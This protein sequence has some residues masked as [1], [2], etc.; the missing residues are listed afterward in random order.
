MSALQ[1]AMLRSFGTEF[2]GTSVKNRRATILDSGTQKLSAK[3]LPNIARALVQILQR[4]K[5]KNRYL[6]IQDFSCS[7]RDIVENLEW[8]SGERWTVENVKTAE[9]V[10]QAR[11]RLAGGDNAAL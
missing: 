11:A 3:M 9:R 6:F 5:T 4:P 8:L 1:L 7:Q 10:E 2:L